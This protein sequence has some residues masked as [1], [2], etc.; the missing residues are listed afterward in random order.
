MSKVIVFGT[1]QTAEIAYHYLKHD[2]TY[3]VVAFTA[4]KEYIKD[5]TF[6]KL[7]LIPFDKISKVYSPT[8]YKMFVALS[9][10]NLNR[11]RADKYMQAKKKGYELVSYISS[12]SGIIGKIKTGDNCFILENQVIQPFSNIGN[13]VFIWGGVLIGHHSKIGD[14]TWITSETSI[15]G[16]TVIGPYCFIGMNA[17]IGHMKLIG[18]NCFIGAN[19]LI[20]KDVPDNSVFIEKETKPYFLD[21]KKFLKITKMK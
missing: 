10:K 9:Y 13:N 17:T 11:L 2:S 14:H 21:S 15:G 6:M 3:D 5:K 8:Q 18:K 4:D 16:N 7:P 12:Q 19:T 1:G 20:T